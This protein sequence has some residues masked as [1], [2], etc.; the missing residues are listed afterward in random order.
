MSIEAIMAQTREVLS[1][2][3]PVPAARQVARSG[4]LSK[5][6]HEVLELVARGEP[7]KEIAKELF[8]SENTVK[9][10]VTSLLN[11]LGASSRGQVVALAIQRHLL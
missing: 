4:L 8:I 10:H 1:M 7:N 5:R 6:E 2:L 11:K 9:Y 3:L